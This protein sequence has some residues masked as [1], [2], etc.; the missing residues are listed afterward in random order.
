MIDR[1]S[2]RIAT[3]RRAHVSRRC[4]P[5][6]RSKSPGLLRAPRLAMRSEGSR[7]LGDPGRYRRHVEILGFQKGFHGRNAFL[8]LAALAIDARGD[9]RVIAQAIGILAAA[10]AIAVVV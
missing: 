2:I 10:H 6:A 9:P 5:P 7:G 1:R 4:R 3:L 8:V